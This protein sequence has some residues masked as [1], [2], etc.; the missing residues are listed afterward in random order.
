MARLAEG[1]RIVVPDV[2]GLG[3]SEPVDRLD[4]PSFAGW[5][6]ELLRLTCREQPA[7][8]AHSLIGS[9]VARRATHGDELARRLVIY[10]VPGIG[11]YR[12]PLGLLV[13]AIR[14]D[15]RPTRRNF[16]RFLPWPFLDPDRTRAQDPGWFEAFTEYMV[17]RGA[18]PHV[19]R[20]MRQLIKAGTERVPDDE[21]RRIEVPTTLLWGRHDRMTP[22]ASARRRAP[23]SAGRST[24][25]T[26]PATC[27]T[28]SAR[29]RSSAPCA[30]RSGTGGWPV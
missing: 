6:D 14:S 23:G 22:C 26:T 17:S 20:A 1:H 15:L 11:P 16:E 27:R 28:S 13:G 25:S 21:L 2:P 10:G 9:L 24:C 5:L 12:L 7:L 30:P 3:E 19:K 29:T 18:V 4:A 8:I